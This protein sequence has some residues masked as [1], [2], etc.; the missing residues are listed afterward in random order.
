M[1][2]PEKQR[3]AVLLFALCAVIILLTFQATFA[4]RDLPGLKGWSS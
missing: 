1:T 3:R 2:Q 4:E